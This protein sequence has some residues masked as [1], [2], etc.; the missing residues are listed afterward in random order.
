MM[1]FPI[2]LRDWLPAL[3]GYWLQSLIPS[4]MRKNKKGKR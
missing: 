4:F 2:R 3:L 1:G